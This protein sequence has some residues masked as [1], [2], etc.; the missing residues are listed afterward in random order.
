[1][2]WAR[3]EWDWEQWDKPW[4]VDRYFI[5]RSPLPSRE[6]LREEENFPDSGNVDRLK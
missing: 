1:M 6:E 3:R 4:L 5:A 2:V